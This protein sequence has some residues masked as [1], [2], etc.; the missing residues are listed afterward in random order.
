[1]DYVV[2][3][4]RISSSQKQVNTLLI[5]IILVYFSWDIHEAQLYKSLKE[6]W[7]TASTRLSK[8]VWVSKA[9]TEAVLL[10]KRFPL[11]CVNFNILVH[12]KVDTVTVL[13]WVE[14]G[15][16][17]NLLQLYKILVSNRHVINNSN[18]V[19]RLNEWLPTHFNSS[20]LVLK[21]KVCVFTFNF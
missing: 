14:I 8:L 20:F 21:L 11:G 4:C 10:L 15:L 13:Q 3:N 9:I 19:L 12:I 17:N 1:M 18:K 6:M 7:S 16:T 2:V 5:Y